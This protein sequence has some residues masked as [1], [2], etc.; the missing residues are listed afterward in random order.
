MQVANLRARGDAELLE[1]MEL[2]ARQTQ[3]AIADNV[4]LQRVNDQLRADLQTL[5]AVMQVRI[6]LNITLFNYLC[7]VW[8]SVY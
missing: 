3:N 5:E 6:I 2:S 8:Y 7:C 1:Q 4:N